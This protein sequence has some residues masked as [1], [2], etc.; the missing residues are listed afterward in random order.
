M[1]GHEGASALLETARLALRELGDDD[2]DAVHAYASDP[3]VVQYMT[4][5]PNSI[6]DTWDFLERAQAQAAAEPRLDYAVAVARTDSR[7]VIG[8]VGL[9]LPTA[10]SHQAMLG[11]C[12][13]REAW[14]QGYATEAG[15]AM[16]DFGF[17]VL[18]LHRIWAGCDADNAGSIRVLEKLGMSLEGRHR[19]DVRVRGTYR[20][21][22][23]FGLLET[24]RGRS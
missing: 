11:Y 8:C 4:W 24:E 18:G 3:E 23:V 20:D 16:V 22:L 5:G 6:Q 12:Y 10:E 9:H 7:R 1:P 17:D 13:R 21:S 19:H 2:F 15:S 14:G